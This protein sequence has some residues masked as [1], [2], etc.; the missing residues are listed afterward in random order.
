MSDQKHNDA[1]PKRRVGKM[2]RVRVFVL[3]VVLALVVFGIIFNI[4]I[5]SYSSLGFGEL[6]WL[7]PIGWLE[8]AISGGTFAIHPLIG[9]LIPIVFML[10]FGKAFCSW[11]CPT[12]IIQRMFRG[13]R[14]AEGESA[15][16]DAE[17]VSIDDESCACEALPPVGGKRDGWHFDSRW[18]IV[19]VALAAA[20]IFGFPVFCLICPVGLT[21]ASIAS[22]W[23]LLQSNEM[24]WGVIVFPLLLGL[25]LGI[26]SKWCK[27]LCPI[28]AIMSLVSRANKTF[29]VSVDPSTCL[30]SHGCD[31]H[32]CVDTCPEL[33]DPHIEKIPECTKCGICMDACP[34]QAISMKFLARAKRSV[35][36]KLPESAE[37]D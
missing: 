15:T 3:G 26:F 18:I 35:S 16:N 7:C 12:P 37:K 28:S 30:R 1:S 2:T 23:H 11:I 5:G 21:F 20:F 10:I 9:V 31:C 25:E 27:V 19:V 32:V 17:K 24:T 4:G 34:A 33:V 36:S 8:T 6:A 29:H 22:I 13:K 14:N